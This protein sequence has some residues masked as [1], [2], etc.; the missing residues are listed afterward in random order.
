MAE[1][2]LKKKA[3]LVRKLC[4]EATTQAGSGHPTSC[5]SAAD[6]T[7]VLFDKH[8]IYDVKTPDNLCNDRF[9]LSKGHAAPL[10]YT[11]FAL[12]GGLSLEELKK[13]RKFGSRLEGHPMPSFPFADAATGSLGQGLSIAAGL[14]YISKY[15]NLGFSTYVLLGDVELAEGQV[16][17]AANFCSYNKLSNLIA[18]VDVN[19]FGQSQ[20]TMFGHDIEKYQKRFE[21]FGF[22]TRV[23]DGHDFSEI[24]KA[25]EVAK[26]NEKSVPFVILAKTKKGK[27]PWRE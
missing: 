19:K 15:E 14:A 3:A 1:L 9:V 21:A 8:F 17:E 22:A 25:F 23:I 27:G 18:I 26:Q 6:L 11:L 16:W 10:L 12:A 7:T 5:L 13:L 24:D 4:L 2:D 20:E